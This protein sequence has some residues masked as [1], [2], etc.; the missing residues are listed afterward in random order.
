MIP[1]SVLLP[2]QQRWIADQKPVKLCEKS[3]RV[4]LSWSEAADSALEAAKAIGSD[5]WYIGYSKD[6]AEEFIRDVAFWARHFQLA[7]DEMDELVLNDDEKDILAFRINFASGKR[8][9]ALSSR[10]T[11][12]RGKKGRVIIDEAAFHPDLKGLLK[13][14][15][16]LL[17]WG[18]R[19]M[20]ISTH[21]GED[22]EFNVLL[23]EVRAG[24]KPYSL[25]RIT[26][27]DAL[28]D[29]L[30][31]RICLMTGRP[32]SPEAEA[33]WRTE[34]LAQYGDDADEELLCIPSS[35]GGSWLTRQI[36]ERCMIRTSP[37]LR[38]ALK[39]EFATL[40]EASREAEIASWCAEYLEPL[41]AALPPHQRHFLGEDFGRSG[42]LTVLAPFTEQQDLTYTAP[43][44]LELRNV[45][46]EAQKQ[47]AFFLLDRLPK[48]TKGAFDA[49][50]NGS[51]LAEVAKLRYGSTRIEQV[52]LSEPWYREHM[53][54]FKASL[55]EKT[56][57]FSQDA[58]VMQDL[59]AIAMTKG[60]AKVPESKRYK[61]S[62]GKERHGDAAMALVLGHYA[63]HSDTGPAAGT[64][65]A[66]P[67]QQYHSER[68][69]RLFGGRRAA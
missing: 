12:L 32:W 69:G 42:D 16:A 54:K 22:N 7:A 14:A 19:V 45:P 27:D 48:F 38:L 10:P 26:L 34:I 37:V 58:D 64:L 51:Y 20:V 29:G 13:S 17:M 8:V 44:L 25:H 21:N 3:R 65:T 46:F 1:A 4:G 39:D 61:G 28:S 56:L 2:P 49:R 55:E 33:E 60:V 43:F 53:P 40:S 35:G 5:T 11:N 63:A 31:K 24:K 68:R 59:K 66:T 41:L 47:I 18:G 30:F 50:G 62:D 9:T 67:T 15:L 23:N 6:M 52:Q 57:L 36:I